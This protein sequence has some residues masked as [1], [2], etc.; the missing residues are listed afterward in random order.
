MARISD[1]YLESLPAEDYV[2]ISIERI[3]AHH[4]KIDE[5]WKS[6]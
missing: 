4:A 1:D 3:Y 5:Y 2:H 6:Y